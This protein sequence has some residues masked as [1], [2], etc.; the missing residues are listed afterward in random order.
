MFKRAGRRESASTLLHDS[1]GWSMKHR[2]AIVISDFSFVSLIFLRA[3]Y[4]G[5]SS[6]RR[7]TPRE[8]HYRNIRFGR[9]AWQDRIGV[10]RL[11]SSG[12]MKAGPVA[13]FPFWFI[14]SA[15]K[16]LSLPF[17]RKA[18]KVQSTILLCRTTRS[19]R[20]NR[21]VPRFSTILEKGDDGDALRKASLQT[22][23]FNNY[24][25]KSL[26]R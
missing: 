15:V 20:N 26:F 24:L 23:Y 10:C 19:V 9:C 2:G 25:N 13:F 22:C 18:V 6:P 4:S 14:Y 21:W 1:V 8:Y 16:L 12:W 3:N 17:I 7:A 11:H 5:R